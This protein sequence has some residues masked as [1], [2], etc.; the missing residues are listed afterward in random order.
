MKPFVCLLHLHTSKNPVKKS[1][2]K[3]LQ[4]WAC[5][6]FHFNRTTVPSFTPADD[7]FY[8][9]SPGDHVKFWGLG[10]RMRE[11]PLSP[12][13]MER[14]FKEG[15]ETAEWISPS[16]MHLSCP[17][18]AAVL[19]GTSNILC[20]TG[21]NE[22]AGAGSKG[23]DFGRSFLAEPLLSAQGWVFE[24]GLVSHTLCAVHG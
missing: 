24:Q 22:D 15:R 21:T 5:F 8:L 3:K 18:G 16:F 17:Q 7:G 10:A 23:W 2:N 14:R 12:E 9:K 19:T 1:R 4:I 11:E 20:I 13:G 6:Y